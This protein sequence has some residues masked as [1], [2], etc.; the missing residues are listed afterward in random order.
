MTGD[1][2]MGILLGGLVACLVLAVVQDE[3]V[4]HTTADETLLHTGYGIHGTVD[5]Q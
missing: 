1:Q 5:I 2:L 4:A 3:V